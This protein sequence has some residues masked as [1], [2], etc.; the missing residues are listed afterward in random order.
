MMRSNKSIKL[1][2]LFLL[3]LSGFTIQSQEQS[4]DVL[5]VQ[6]ERTVE[7][8][9]FGASIRGS[10]A[11]TVGIGSSVINGD[12]V[13]P[14]FEI[15]FHGGY[16]RFINR[17][18]NINLTYHKFNLAYKDVFNEGF[19]SFDLNLEAN[20][21]PE[22]SFT[23]FVFVGGGLHASNYF[24]TT[25]TKIQGGAG[26]EYLVMPQ[27]GLKLS[28]DYNHLFDDELDGLIFGEADDIYWRM[29]FGLNIYFGR[30]SKNK[31]LKGDE[32][33]VKKSNPIDGGY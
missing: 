7:N 30:F 17:Y 5:N 18:V 3:L 21:L 4:D 8:K 31:T 9:R 26:I 12:Y 23:P 27:L 6:P 15:Y 32:P 13:D 22:A 19:M 10:N 33:T 1:L 24:E 25:Q 16:K 29:A 2:L 11:L 14:L 20:I 28:A